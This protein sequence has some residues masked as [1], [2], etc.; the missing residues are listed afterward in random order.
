MSMS[1][2][3]S[4]IAAAM[5]LPLYWIALVL[6]VWC[7]AVSIW[8][9]DWPRAL[10]FGVMWALCAWTLRAIQRSMR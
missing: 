3:R 7:I 10:L 8:S 2:P 5:V 9:H 4:P 6:L 1:E